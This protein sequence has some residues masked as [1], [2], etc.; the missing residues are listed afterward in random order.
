MSEDSDAIASNLEGDAA[1]GRIP[2]LILG[3]FLGAGKTTVLNHL[4]RH[5]NGRR[6]A[7][8]VNDVGE[9]NIDAD[10]A[11]EVAKVDSASSDDLV[12]LSNGCI[13]CGLQGAFGE[14]VINLARRKPDCIVVEAS[15]VAEPQRIVSSL[16]GVDA[17]GVSALDFVRIVNL[18]TLVDAEWWIKKIQKAYEP[19]RRSLMLFSDPRRPLSELLTIQVECASVIV[20]NKT[21]L[22]E[23]DALRR[24]EDALAAMSPRAEVLK[25][26]EG[27]VDIE[28][29]LGKERFDA[30]TAFSSSRCDLEFDGSGKTRNEGAKPIDRY[31]YGEFGLMTFVYRSRRPINHEKLVGY[32]RSGIHG[33]LRSKGFVWTDSEPDRV[34]YLSLAGDI[35]RFDYLG[36]WMHALVS[37]GQMDRSQIPPEIWRKWDAKTGDRRQEIVFIG[38]DLNKQ[39]MEE[40]LDRFAVEETMEVL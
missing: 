16:T 27:R 15:G 29:L 17:E 11:R 24:S 39:Q 1:D 10:L 14:A 9:V 34:G 22:V 38:I 23:E 7:V 36:K 30:S 37:K 6:L 8:L 28:Q 18:V 26:S 20:L 19:V 12:E 13:C 4:L 25:T 33:L 2:L 32:L 35:L 3:G 21:D 5:A 31:D 40:D